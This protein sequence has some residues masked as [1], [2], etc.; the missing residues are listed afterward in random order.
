MILTLGLA[1]CSP[2]MDTDILVGAWA[3]TTSTGG[4]V[5]FTVSEELDVVDGRI[6]PDDTCGGLGLRAWFDFEGTVDNTG[7]MDLTLSQSRPFEASMSGDA[8]GDATLGGDAE[9]TINVIYDAFTGATCNATFAESW[10]AEPGAEV[11]ADGDGWSSLD[12]CDESNASV[13][14]DA[15]ET[16][17]GSD[18]DCDGEA[19]EGCVD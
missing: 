9:G 15:P 17:D 4:V 7:A 16:C 11:D 3:G 6:Q 8:V 19:D 5:S 13:H 2:T 10:T 12:D 14:P 18:E 1:G